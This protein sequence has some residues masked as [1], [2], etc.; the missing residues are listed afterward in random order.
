MVNPFGYDTED[1][2]STADTSEPKSMAYAA[3]DASDGP[4]G[5]HNITTLSCELEPEGD[6][7]LR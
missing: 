5:T 3:F 7:V 6:N 4:N 2:E 1:P